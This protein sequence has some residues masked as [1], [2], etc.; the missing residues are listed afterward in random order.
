MFIAVW[1]VSLG[2]RYLGCRRMLW[3]KKAI[4]V[5]APGWLTVI[6]ILEGKSKTKPNKTLH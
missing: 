3:F 1:S 6:Y 4:N 2:V 5:R